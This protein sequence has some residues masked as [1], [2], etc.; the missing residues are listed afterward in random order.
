MCRN[1]GDVYSDNI[2]FISDDDMTKQIWS[3]V[4]S[5]ELIYCPLIH[6]ILSFTIVLGLKAL[7]K[8]ETFMRNNSAI[9]QYDVSHRAVKIA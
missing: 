9:R 8:Y 5:N 3:S 4:S 7:G 6:F 1:V 2:V